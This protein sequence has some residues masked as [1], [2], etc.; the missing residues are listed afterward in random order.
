MIQRNIIYYPLRFNSPAWLTV[1]KIS[2]KSFD[3]AKKLLFP[4]VKD[5]VLKSNN[6]TIIVLYLN[7]TNKIK[8]THEY[9][10]N[11]V[12]L[13]NSKFSLIYIMKE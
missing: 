13:G 1:V 8:N 9:V 2:N 7:S 5:S 3:A 11:N 6:L 12:I 4:V 10:I